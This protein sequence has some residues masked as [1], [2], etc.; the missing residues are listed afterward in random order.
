MACWP[1]S[2]PARSKPVGGIGG[3]G[4]YHPRIDPTA[5]SDIDRDEVLAANERFYAAFE[6]RNLDAMSAIWSTI[7]GWCAPTP[8]GRPCGAGARWPPR[9]S[10]CSRDRC[11]PVHPHR[12]AR[13]GGRRPG[14]VSLDENVIGEQLGTTV[15]A[16]NL[17]VRAADGWLM[18][19]HHGSAVASSG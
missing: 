13:G 11:P 18:V 4:V 16:L 12:R 9:G 3:G 17:F 8:V 15:A 19:A 1:R 7:H 10:P 5:A 2:Q 6:G 14:W